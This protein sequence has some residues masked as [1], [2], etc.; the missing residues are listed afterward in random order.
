MNPAPASFPV[1]QFADT[2]VDPKQYIEKGTGKAKAL[3]YVFGLLGLVVLAATTFGVGLLA[4]PIGLVAEY[5]NRKKAMARLKGSALEVGPEQ[6]PELHQCAQDFA[7]RL[8][9]KEVPAIYVVE[10]N[11]LN[12]AAMR[13]GSRQV[14]VLIDDIVDSCLRSGDQRAIG[15]IL[16]HEMAHH[17]LGHTG[18]VQG[19]LFQAYKKL[20]RLNEFSCDAVARAL[21]KE[22]SVAVN[23][24]LVM[25]TGPQL[26]PYVNRAALLRQ[27]AE[28]TADKNS[29]KSERALSHP[30]L[31]RRLQRMLAS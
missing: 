24:L 29:V 2:P 23:A 27:A 7:L 16:A 15:F 5:F 22:E 18:I 9:L 12:A 25:L 28:V 31:L 20:S 4:L 8:G 17:A 3:G 13:I 10:S 1:L 6:L 14:I 21:V 26:V 30:L 11:V 19:F